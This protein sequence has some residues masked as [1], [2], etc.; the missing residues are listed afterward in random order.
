MLLLLGPQWMVWGDLRC[1]GLRVS[2]GLGPGWGSYWTPVWVSLLE[3]GSGDP[4]LYISYRGTWCPPGSILPSVSW[5]APYPRKPWGPWRS[6]S[7][8][9]PLISLQETEPGVR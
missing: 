9:L 8:F 5:R 6:S 7:S 3:W 1:Y 2:A 4:A